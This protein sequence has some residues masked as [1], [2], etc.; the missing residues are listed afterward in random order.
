MSLARAVRMG[1][2]AWSMRPKKADCFCGRRVTASDVCSSPIAHPWRGW[3][4]AASV[5]GRRRRRWRDT[6]PACTSKE[7]KCPVGEKAPST[8]GEVPRRGGWGAEVGHLVS[9]E[10]KTHI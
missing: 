9:G 2:D 10:E 8:G 7:A 3:S 6:S 1:S 5:A 4:V